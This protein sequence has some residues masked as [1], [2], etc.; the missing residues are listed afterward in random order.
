[1]ST[2]ISAA[3]SSA[4]PNLAASMGRSTLFGLISN[5]AQVGT[6]AVTVPIITHYL[7]LIG[8]GMWNIVMTT[9]TYMRFGAVGVKTAFQKYVAES[10]GTGDYERANKLLSTG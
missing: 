10:T 8:Y 6:R 3:P 2:T 9:A 1:M 7:G 5:L 4:P